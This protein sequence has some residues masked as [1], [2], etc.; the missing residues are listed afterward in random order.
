MK[1]SVEP[2]EVPVGMADSSQSLPEHIKHQQD[3]RCTQ[4]FVQSLRLLECQQAA[5]V[6]A[7]AALKCGG[8]R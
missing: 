3:E 7:L 4:I 6:K 5:Q 2:T 8:W 1:Q